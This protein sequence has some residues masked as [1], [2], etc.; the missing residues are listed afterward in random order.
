VIVALVD[1]IIDRFGITYGVRRTPLIANAVVYKVFADNLPVARAVLRV[2][3]GYISDV[4]VYRK[5]DRRRGIATALCALIEA[6]LGRPLRP[7]HMRSKAGRA[8][9]ASRR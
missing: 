8:F 5:T 3:K 9:W 7:N 1:S 6:D 2:D 4:L